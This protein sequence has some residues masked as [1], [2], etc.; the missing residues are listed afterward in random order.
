MSLARKN[1]G[2]PVPHQVLNARYHEQEAHIIAQ[3]GVPG[4]VTIATN[5][6]GRG[7]DI[8]LGGNDSLPR[9]RL[10]E[11]GDCRRRPPRRRPRRRR[12][13]TSRCASG[14]TTIAL[15]LGDEWIE[16]RLKKWV[17]PHG[18]RSSPGRPHPGQPTRACEKR[19]RELRTRR[20]D[21]RAAQAQSA[22]RVARQLG[23]AATGGRATATTTPRRCRLARHA[24]CATRRAVARRCRAHLELRPHQR[25][26]VPL[27]ARPALEAC[28]VDRQ[29]RRAGRAPRSRP[30][31]AASSP[32]SSPR[33]IAIK[34]RCAEIQADVAEK[35][36]QAH[37]R[38]RPVRDR[39]GAPREPAHRQPAARPLRAARAIPAAP[40]STCRWKTT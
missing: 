7:T 27:H 9:P 33:S 16:R 15:R 39:H 18:P 21:R 2:D 17:E 12:R 23:H 34:R 35:K 37:R 36:K 1:S 13:R 25:A 6:A 14:W 4:G 40:S 11:G 22:R 3:A 26:A 10:A 8:Q 24:S 28:A 38:R 31:L 20:G 19:A 32:R 30:E 29:E 5:M